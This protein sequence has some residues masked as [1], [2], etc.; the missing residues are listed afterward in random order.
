MGSWDPSEEFHNDYAKSQGLILFSYHKKFYLCV[1]VTMLLM[2]APG[3]P[4]RQHDPQF[5][6]EAHAIGHGTGVWPPGFVS[7]RKTPFFP[8][9]FP[10]PLERLHLHTHVGGHRAS[11]HCLRHFFCSSYLLPGNHFLLVF[12]FALCFGLAQY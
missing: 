6:R 5:D 9:I 10:L 12:G 2:G 11:I 8:F 4:V 1:Q 3:P 7:G